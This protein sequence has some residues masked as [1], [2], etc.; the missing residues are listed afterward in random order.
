M[1]SPSLLFNKKL[2]SIIVENFSLEL[3]LLEGKLLLLNGTDFL[4]LYKKKFVSFNYKN[5]LN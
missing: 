3:Y 2:E 1:S 4:S 5:I